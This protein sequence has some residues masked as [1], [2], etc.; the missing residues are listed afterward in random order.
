MK[1]AALTI[2]AARAEPTRYTRI[3]RVIIFTPHVSPAISPPP[4]LLRTSFNSVSNRPGQ[5][6]RSIRTRN[7][8]HLT[9]NE[10]HLEP[11]RC[12]VPYARSIIPPRASHP[13]C[14]RWLLSVDSG[15]LPRKADGV[16]S[17]KRTN[18]WSSPGFAGVGAS[19]MLSCQG[20][21][22]R[23][24]VYIEIPEDYARDAGR[25]RSGARRSRCARCRLSR[26]TPRNW[27]AL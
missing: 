13:S 19:V 3:V 7:E 11:S 5:Q 26:A 20:G 14:R 18:I 15:R 21:E 1:E 22:R 2:T 12:S 23:M 17:N 10:R 16:D 9:R 24:P 4:F 6:K 25:W 8:R 27:T